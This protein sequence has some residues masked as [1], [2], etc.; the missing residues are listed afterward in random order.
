M[1]AKLIDD[2][3]DLANLLRHFLVMIFQH[4]TELAVCLVVM[5][6]GNRGF[7]GKCFYVFSG[8]HCCKL[9]RQI[10]HHDNPFAPRRFG[11]ASFTDQTQVGEY[12]IELGGFDL[13]RQNTDST[14]RACLADIQVTFLGG[15]HH[16]R[17]G[18]GCR[19]TLD[20]LHSLQAIHAGHHVVHENDAGGFVNQVVESLLR[21]FDGV[22]M[23]V[24]FFQH[25][26]Q[27]DAC[28]FGIIN[29]QSKPVCHL[30]CDHV[31]NLSLL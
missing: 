21:G 26:F 30:Q 11:S 17:N 22:D 1:I 3:A 28:G 14:E 8:V 4:F 12:L 5:A 13:L 29:N 31:E 20:R 7:P 18:G 19:I 16:D 25:A 23:Q 15:V 9:F 6:N 2:T 10:V 27:G 24:V